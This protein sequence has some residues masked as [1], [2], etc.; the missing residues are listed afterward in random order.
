VTNVTLARCGDFLRHRLQVVLAMLAAQSAGAGR[1]NL[2][3][4]QHPVEGTHRRPRQRRP[5]SRGMDRRDQ[6]GGRP[7]MCARPHMEVQGVAKGPDGVVVQGI[8]DREHVQRGRA[9]R[10]LQPDPRELRHPRAALP[11]AQ[12]EVVAGHHEWRQHRVVRRRSLAA[13]EDVRMQGQREGL[14]RLEEEVQG[15]EG[16]GERPDRRRSLLPG[17][18]SELL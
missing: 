18:R 7:L 4:F 1:I 10:R 12:P 9:G 6:E 13:I 16:L 11:Q 3:L 14:L 17:D 5:G 8:A 15:A 2:A